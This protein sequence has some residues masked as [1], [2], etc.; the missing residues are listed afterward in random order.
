MTLDKLVTMVYLDRWQ[1]DEKGFIGG[2]YV[3]YFDLANPRPSVPDVQRELIVD[4]RIGE[5]V[6]WSD[7]PFRERLIFKERVEGP[8]SIGLTVSPSEDMLT[9]RL[10]GLIRRLGT[11][12]ASQFL[13]L[14]FHTIS[15]VL[16]VA[17]EAGLADLRH[18]LEKTLGY[19]TKRVDPREDDT[20]S[21]DVPLKTPVELENPE[22]ADHDDPDEKKEPLKSP[23]ESN[24][25]AQFS[26]QFAPA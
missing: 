25:Y 7:R 18:S 4:E 24:G 19:G 5:E 20:V 6:D 10:S 11:E 13:N 16:S 15:R 1:L 12:R 17:R 3:F 2:P 14:R 8:F 26:L 21:L 9:S 22:A 23:G